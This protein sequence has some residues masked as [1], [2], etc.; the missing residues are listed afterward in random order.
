MQTAFV[1]NA[2]DSADSAT[3]NGAADHS[4]VLRLEADGDLSVRVLRLSSSTH[5]D[6]DPSPAEVVSRR[7]RLSAAV[8]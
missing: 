4:A 7:F 5:P 1:F 8:E 3:D 6:A 2:P